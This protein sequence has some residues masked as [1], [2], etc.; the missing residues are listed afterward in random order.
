MNMLETIIPKSDQ[1]TADDFLGGPRT[2]T[3]TKVELTRAEQPC[4][5]FFDG[6]EGR[7]YRPCMI[8]RRV[9][10]KAWGEDANAY[11][12]KSM[13]LFRDDTV[14]YGALAVSGIR[15]SHLSHIPS[16]FTMVLRESR[17]SSKPFTFQPLPVT[18][19]APAVATPP[20]T[21]TSEP[22]PLPAKK[23]TMAD[24]VNDID[25]MLS[26]DGAETAAA[27]A[28]VIASDRVV[29]A[30]ANAKGDDKARLDGIIAAARTRTAAASAPDVD[31]SEAPDWL[32][33]DRQ[34]SEGSGAGA[35]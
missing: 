27:V 18:A 32:G 11:L 9:M 8:M 10:V 14:R 20:E 5:V 4:A 12:G 30:V 19:G 21:A 22:P 15:I 17:K 33:P 29:W 25:A 13:T 23:R 2:I 6:D 35:V 1:Q 24:V 16:A 28:L 34:A 3:I 31:D 7:P 26:P